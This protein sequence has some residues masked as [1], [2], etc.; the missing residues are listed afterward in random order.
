MESKEV[1]DYLSK[2]SSQGVEVIVF[3]DTG[4]SKELY[5]GLISGIENGATIPCKPDPDYKPD[6]TY[7]L[8]IFKMD[9]IFR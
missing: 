1:Y 6:Y 3:K 7:R 5:N 2:L 4:F 8:R 9:V